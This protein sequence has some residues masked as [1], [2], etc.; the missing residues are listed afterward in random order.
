MSKLTAPLDDP[1]YQPKH[2]PIDGQ[3][4]GVVAKWGPASQL[5]WFRRF[6]SQL[7]VRRD[8]DQFY[9]HSEHH[10]GLCCFS[11]EDEGDLGV[12]GGGHCCCRDERIGR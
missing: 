11:C 6:G 3:I 12:Q 8:W 2:P 4:P 5:R 1:T 10:R 9:C 7:G